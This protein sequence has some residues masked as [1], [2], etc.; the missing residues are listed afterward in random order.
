VVQA[1]RL[2]A[3][4]WVCASAAQA[5]EPSA[6]RDALHRYFDGEWAERWAFGGLGVA[7]LATAGALWAEG[8]APAR[9]AA[10]P[11]ALVGLLQLGLA[12]GLQLRT[13]AQVAA[14]DAL[15]TNDPPRFLA[16]E[17]ARMR[18][19]NQGFAVYRVVVVGL[20]MA[21]TALAGIGGVSEVRA[22]VGAGLGLGAEA[23]LMLLLDFFADGRGRAWEASLAGL[24]F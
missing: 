11:V 14:L 16:Q 12:F 15:L 4:L 17:S 21:G 19:V 20:F 7:S 9:G 3:L 23:L 6:G 1:L 24:R 10:V 13:P 8:G 5:S 18:R 22:L 2:V